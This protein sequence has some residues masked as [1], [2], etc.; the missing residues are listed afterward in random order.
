[1][2][3]KPGR[4]VVIFT[5]ALR[6]P[7]EERA[8]FLERACAGDENLRR[9]VEALLSAHERVGNFLE[10][11]PLEAGP[12]ARTDEDFDEGQTNGC[13]GNGETDDK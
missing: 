13:G 6:L 10:N 9:E 4:D 7:V 5:E 3:D 1:M 8:A 11:P 2:S 12:P